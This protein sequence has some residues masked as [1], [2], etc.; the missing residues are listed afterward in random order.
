MISIKQKIGKPKYR[1]IITSIEDAIISG[2]LK[3]G[4]QLPSINNIRDAHK[5]S[6][7]TVLMAFNELKTRGIIHSIVG[8][9]YYVLNEDIDVTQKIFLLFDEFNSFKEDLYNSFINNLG[10]NIKVDIYFHHFNYE[11]FSKLI[12]ESVGSYNYYV[13]MPANL[14]NTNL[15][16]QKL[17]QEKVY[18][19]DQIHDD[20]VQY[21]AIFQNFEM[22]I[23]NNLNKALHLIKNYKK[24]VLLFNDDKQPQGMLDGFK[25]FCSL[26]GIENDV[27]NSLQDQ[28][29]EKGDI[30]VIP[31]DKDLLRIIKKLKETKLILSKDI[32]IISYNDT[33]LKEIV[34]GGITTISTDFNKMG[35]RL[36]KMLLNKEQLRIE[37]TNAL[38]LRNSL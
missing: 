27:I 21:S 8:K 1:Q 7:D 19:L 9:G 23:I 38:I 17:P 3:K 36:A 16:I 37:N 34:E 25:K 10:D 22:D 4:D 35:E 28:I 14:N 32:G 15:V 18:I 31:D 13:I 2:S 11:V 26:N 6:R 20:L 33:L 12:Y 29:P 24:L 30:Y 5:L